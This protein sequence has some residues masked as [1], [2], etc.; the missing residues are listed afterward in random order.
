MQMTEYEL[1][2][3]DKLGQAIEA[4]KWSNDG[5]VQLIKLSGDHLNL[6]TIPVY[7]ELHNMSYAGVKKCRN[8][9]KIFNVKFVIDNL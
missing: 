8:I 2:S 9:I 7:A 5:L 6:M 3:L 4:G 1:N